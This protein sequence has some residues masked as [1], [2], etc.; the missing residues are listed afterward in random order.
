MPNAISSPAAQTDPISVIFLPSGFALDVPES[1]S[2]SSVSRAFKE[3]PW[4][5]LYNLG[6]EPKSNLES[7]TFHW[8]HALADVFVHVLTEQPALE[9]SREQTEVPLPEEIALK[10][11]DALP[12]GIGVDNVTIDWLTQA[13]LALTEVFCREIE[14]YQG[15]VELYFAEKLQDLHIPE[16]IFFHLVERK[17]AE[18]DAPFA[19]LATYSTRGSNGKVS[20]HPLSYALVEYKK[21]QDKLV[22]LLSCLNRAADA[23]PL[24]EDLMGSGELFHPLKLTSDEAYQLLKCVP[25]IEK[26]GIACRLPDWWRKKNHRVT[27]SVSMGKGKDSRLT[28]STLLEM[29]PSLTV[30]GVRLTQAEIKQL[31]AAS[32]GL[33]MLKGKWVEVDHEKLHALLQ[34]M[35]KYQGDLS[36]V[37]ALRMQSGV[38]TR[39]AAEDTEFTSGKFLGQLMEHLR[40][41]DVPKDLTVP[42][43]VHASLRPYQEA[44][45]GWLSEMASYGFGACLADD[46]GLGKTLQVLTFLEQLYLDQP[47]ARVLLVVPASLIGNWEKE[48]QKFTPNLTTC[49]LHGQ[50]SRKLAEKLETD[51]A[52][53]TI[54]TYSMAKN[55][56]SL[57]EKHWTCLVLDEA[58]AIKNPQALQSRAVK[59]IPSVIRIAMTGTPIE[60]N[61]SNL[62]SLFDFLNKGLLGSAREFTKYTK[63]LEENP[64]GYAK[65]KRMVSPF[66]L[67][68]L[69]TDKSIISDLPDKIETTD[70]IEL[71]KK[72]VT[73]YHQEVRSL[74]EKLAT[75]DGMARRG[76]V[77]QSISRFKQLCNHPDQYLGESSYNPSE[78]GKF[79]ALQE[80]C[81]SI[82]DRRERVLVFT[83]YREITPHLDSFLEGIF[84]RKGLVISGEVKVK[85][86]TKIVDQFNGEDYVPYMVLTIKAGGTGLNLTSASHV[87]LFDRWWNPAVESQAI[88]RAFRIGQT[89]DVLV[90][91][92][93]ARSSIEEKIADL[94]ASKEELARN[95]V[96]E[97]SE[98]WLTELS[99]E[100]ILDLVR[101]EV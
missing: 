101:L 33:V 47:E 18:D 16:R 2:D 41:P 74:S 31:L 93:V 95:V 92:F 21:S 3:S 27:L 59:K 68:R 29:I 89:R 63:A 39:D 52:F 75:T 11:L 15:T 23:C 5:A 86:R 46:M 57:Q 51:E 20:H 42:E 22:A 50:T 87:I 67:R 9:I 19:F 26:A 80:I 14:Q 17:D 58:Q 32:E 49:I 64:T 28:M 53:I 24:I 97:N 100:E 25:E 56:E 12:W 65:L 8:L 85:E 82:R 71:S 38:E 79:A 77:L 91:K 54:T 60:N 44:G 55:I 90:H 62:W 45:F 84:G 30:D 36:L 66:I 10:N 76:L 88:D 37:Q 78:S 73:L 13:F 83:Q 72:Q 48:I 96:G 40:H 4:Q 99:N 81:E 94:I 1:L 61:L 34:E 7:P 70:Y 6:F 43:E 35:D 69:K 98:V